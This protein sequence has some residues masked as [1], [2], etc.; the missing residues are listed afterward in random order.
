MDQET[1]M[2]AVNPLISKCQIASSTGILDLNDSQ[3]TEIPDEVFNFMSNAGTEIKH[4]DLSGNLME[5]I[6]PKLALDFK[7]ITNLNIA[8]NLLA[9]L[10]KE[11]GNLR[12]LESLNISC[13]YLFELPDVVF[14][15]PHLIYLYAQDNFITEIDV[16]KPI[17][18]DNLAL[19]DLR[20]NTLEPEFLRK[21]MNTPTT[22]RLVLNDAD[23]TEND[24]DDDDDQDDDDGFI[25]N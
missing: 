10:P 2:N 14:K 15:L 8:H 13:N 21:L 3:L 6:Q 22:F 11:I 1:L 25:K 20:Y 24:F 18:S 4:C 17:E 9:T 16:E 19:V 5:E 7:F 23:M 12:A